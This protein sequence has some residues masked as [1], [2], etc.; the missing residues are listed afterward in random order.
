MLRCH[1]AV[2][3]L[4]HQRIFTI[5]NTDCSQANLRQIPE[6]HELALSP[7]PAKCLWLSWG[8]QT[9]ALPDY[10]RST[11]RNLISRTTIG[12]RCVRTRSGQGL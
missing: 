1:G 12:L 3:K 6:F 7:T 9:G 10:N 2:T 4:N 11:N 5:G 8:N